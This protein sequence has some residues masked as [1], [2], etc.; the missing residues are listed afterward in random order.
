MIVNTF[1]NGR[2]TSSV[3]TRAPF[4]ISNSTSDIHNFTE[5]A[6]GIVRNIVSSG[7][8]RIGKGGI[9]VTDGD[10]ITIGNGSV[11]TSTATQ[12]PRKR[13]VDE[14]KDPLSLLD[15][16]GPTTETDIERLQCSICLE[17]EKN[18]KLLPCNHLCVCISCAR[19]LYE[20]PKCP[21]CR[22]KIEGGEVVFIS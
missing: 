19:R 16:E 10:S 5:I 6:N 17:N 13:K 18:V 20:T 2:L 1:T 8:V 22:E 11:S 7:S 21:I 14:E 4:G 15:L 3:G 9:T 12:N